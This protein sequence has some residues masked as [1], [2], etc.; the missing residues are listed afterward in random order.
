MDGRVD[1]LLRALL[2]M[3]SRVEHSMRFQKLVASQE[4]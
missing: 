2:E 4:R 1:S 3:E